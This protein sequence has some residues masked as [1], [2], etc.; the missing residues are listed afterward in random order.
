MRS[1]EI[2][3]AD[4]ESRIRFWVESEPDT[5]TVTPR[6]EMQELLTRAFVDA[7]K[8]IDFKYDTESGSKQ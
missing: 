4:G 8:V 1:V 2:V 3:L 6:E 7:T 5:Q